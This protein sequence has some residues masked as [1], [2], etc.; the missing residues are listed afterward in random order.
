MSLLAQ[1]GRSGAKR[2]VRAMHQVLVDVVLTRIATANVRVAPLW[3]PRCSQAPAGTRALCQ[4]EQ[5]RQYAAQPA[6]P[7]QGRLRRKGPDRRAAWVH[8]ALVT[9][10]PLALLIPR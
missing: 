8:V 5:L 9:L 4:T 2:L 10:L 7:A 3:T 6:T 1:L